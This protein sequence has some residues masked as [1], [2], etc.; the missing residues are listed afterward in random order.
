M[1]IEKYHRLF[2]NGEW[3]EAADKRTAEILCPADGEQVAEISIAGATDVD[4]AVDAANA[5]FGSWSRMPGRERGVLINRFADLLQRDIEIVARLE[6]LEIGRPFGE[7]LNVD[8]PSAITTLRHFAGWADKIDGRMIHGPDHFGRAVHSYTSRVPVGAVGVILPWN[9]PTMIAS[10]K[11][12]PALAA[13]CTLVI[14]PALEAPLAVMHLVRLAEEAGFPPGVL[15]V[16][17]GHGQ[18]VGDAL[19]IHDGIAKI[20]FTGSPAVGKQIALKAAEMLRPVT[21]EL[22][23]KAPQ[24]VFEDAD[25]GETAQALAMGIFSNQGEICAAGSRILVHKSIEK[26]L[27]AAL[28]AIAESHVPGHPMDAATTIGSLI[29]KKQYDSVTG[30]IESGLAEGARLATGG[31]ASND[32]GYFVRPTVFSGVT[33]TMRIAREEIFGPV[34]AI[35]PFETE[36]EAVTMA[37]D[38]A[39]SLSANIFTRDVSRAH[40]VADLVHAGTVWV[41]GGGTPDPRT[42][43]G[44]DGLSGIGRELGISSLQSYTKEKAVNILL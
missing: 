10:W 36:E 24:I 44:G 25:V 34:A 5:A 43:W 32:G 38:S 15:N 12:G 29:S 35:M 30:Y 19:V 1:T 6:A 23:G 41:N 18:D 28:T 16:V 8:I 9:A 3:R 4:A 17:A 37:N 31:P 14:K 13:G 26:D 7:P 39:Y 22:G 42:V 2:I 11:L 21:L 33:H 20:T 40:R 27:V